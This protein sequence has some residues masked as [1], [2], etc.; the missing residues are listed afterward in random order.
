MP[1]ILPIFFFKYI[2][3][4]INFW[5]CWVFVAA[6]RLSLVAASKGYSSLLCAGFSL[7]WLLLSWSKGSRRVG[8]SSCGSRALERR[9]SSCGTWAQLLHCMWVLPGPG[10]EPVSP[11]LAGRFS[12]TS[13]PGK[14]SIFVLYSLKLFYS[15]HTI[16]KINI[17]I[18]DNLSISPYIV[19]ISLIMHFLL[20]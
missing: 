8:F 7:R 6:H 19:T 13:P 2:Y 5:L 18:S 4:F 11:A 16:F 15:M 17:I 20:F 10:L 3:L 14:P 1:V 12:T 9:L